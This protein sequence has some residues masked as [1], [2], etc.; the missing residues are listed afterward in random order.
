[1]KSIGKVYL[2]SQQRERKGSDVT[3]FQLD[4]LKLKTLSTAVLKTILLI[5]TW[6]KEDIAFLSDTDHITLACN[7]FT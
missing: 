1:M 4:L 2:V 5:C 7:I 3:V 6:Q